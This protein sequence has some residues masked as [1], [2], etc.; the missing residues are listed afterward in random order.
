MNQNKINELVS[1]YE[2]LD[3]NTLQQIDQFYTTDAY[4][5][6]PFHEFFELPSLIKLYEDM[7]RKIK[8]PKFIITKSFPGEKELVLFWEFKF[9][10][11]NHDMSIS[12]NTLFKFNDEGKIYYH[13]DY[14]DSVGELWS[15]TPV[16][17][18]MIK[19]FY[20]IIF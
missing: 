16:I 12:G 17:G 18:S 13:L 9:K 5:K 4:F 10:A 19:L 20:R 7:F 15:K 14:W 8:E 2:K 6:D 3:Q 11:L 1:W